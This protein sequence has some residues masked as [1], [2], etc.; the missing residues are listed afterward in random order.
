MTTILHFRLRYIILALLSGI[1]MNVS[2]QS[3][4]IN[5][6]V[7][8]TGYN[9]NNNSGANG[10]ITFVVENN[11][12]QAIKITEVGNYC[13]TLH[14]NSVS[15][16]WYSSTSLSGPVTLATPTWNIAASGSVSGI[17]TS[18]IF[19]VLTGINFQIP[20]GAIYR[21]AIH[22]TGPENNYTL[23]TP[24]P[25]TFT[26]AGVTMR[27]GDYQIGGQYVGYA[28]ANNPRFF[29]GSITFE[30]A[31]IPCDDTLTS[32]VINGVSSICPNKQF[33]LA[34]GVPSGTF[35]SGITYQW[36]Y[37]LNGNTWAN[38]TG[39]PNVSAGGAITDMITAN[40]WYRCIV[41]CTSKNETYITPAHK[42]SIAPFY[43]CYCDNMTSVDGGANVGKVAIIN[44]TND[45][46]V[47]TKSVLSTGTGVPVYNNAQANKL[48]TGYHDSLA[49]PCLYRDSTYRFVITQ[50]Q[51]TAT[52]QPS[53]AQVYI[54]FNRDGLYDP[55]TE[56]VF[57]KA[58]DGTGS[59]PEV[60]VLAKKMPSSAQV[61]PTG[62]RV[63]ISEDTVK[64]APCGTITGYGEV[65]DY[66]IKIC[67]RPCDSP[68]K[69]GIV[70]STDTSMCKGYEY[71]LTDTTYAKT[72]SGF[73]RSWQVSGDQKS[74][75]NIFNSEE[76]DTLERVFTGQPLFYR[77]RTIC[78]TTNDTAYSPSTEIKVKPGYKCYCYSKAV[79]GLGL[80]SSDIGG[81]SIG[82]YVHNSGGPHL[83]NPAAYYPRTDFTDNPPIELYTDS[84][85]HFSVFHTMPG[86]E[87]G[88]AKVTIFMD[89]NNNHEY[90]IPA[91]RIY[92][93]FTSIGNHTLVDNVL[94]PMNAILDVPTGM[95]VI[96][97]N[98]VGP[99]TP[100]DS[101]CGPYTS[102]ETEDY[103]LIFRKKIAEGITDAAKLNGFNIHPNP[104][105]GRFN[106]RFSSNAEIDEVK[107]RITNVTGQLVQQHTYGYEGGVFSKELDI[108]NQ[109]AGVYFVE[110]DADGSKLMQKL[111]VQ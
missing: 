3:T 30:P 23:G 51:S 24:T 106:I 21:L 4:T 8:S 71:T 65:E 54:D 13:Q 11:S 66:I 6:T 29:T 35:I 86:T 80:D 62:M 42:V 44:T 68:V 100:S 31:A 63:I 45:D 41:K 39:V 70:V 108:T 15:T 72:V 55:N 37:S 22:N 78:P 67:Y 36:Q 5:T 97:N 49:W 111:I 90:D 85:Y 60:A 56:K 73:N 96:L 77:V 52:L 103:I 83:L 48:Y 74:W 2:A 40:K 16:L 46:S 81:M 110:L 87:H 109:A 10:F 12:G 94:I 79:G 14:N 107:V 26:A 9:G 104:T 17:T 101:G 18:G 61:G 76:K 38:F 59:S 47:M 64:G 69:G 32:A 25:N 91:E 92:T 28:V 34:V 58:I 20:D 53:V 88:D 98:N 57:L 27:V 1:C 102:G 33:S 7:G 95:R 93:G 84:I 82:T 99:N 89:F 43:Y 105:T 50:I 75:F 19:P